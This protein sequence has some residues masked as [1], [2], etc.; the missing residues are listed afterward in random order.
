MAHER[1]RFVLFELN[2]ILTRLHSV[3]AG[4]LGGIGRVILCLDSAHGICKY[5]STLSGFYD[6]LQHS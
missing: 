1:L 2:E 6:R 3:A 4:G 5:I